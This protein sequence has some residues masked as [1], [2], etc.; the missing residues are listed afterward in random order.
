MP[1]LFTDMSTFDKGLE[2]DSVGNTEF[3]AFQ[4]KL[5]VLLKTKVLSVKSIPVVP[6]EFP[7]MVDA[8]LLVAILI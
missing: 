7:Y 2:L 6:C 3:V 1:N 4:E 5:P 8:F